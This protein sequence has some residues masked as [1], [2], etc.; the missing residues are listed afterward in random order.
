M[1]SMCHEGPARLAVGHRSQPRLALQLDDPEDRL[2]LDRARAAEVQLAGLE[3]GPCLGQGREA[4]KA[5]DV[6]GSERR[7]NSGGDTRRAAASVDM[8]TPR[9]IHG[10]TGY[11]PPGSPQGRAAAAGLTV[12]EVAAREGAV[13]HRRLV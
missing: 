7:I 13:P 10:A 4:Q 1:K 9:S 5:A 8:R 6:V 3:P 12:C 2:V 11:I